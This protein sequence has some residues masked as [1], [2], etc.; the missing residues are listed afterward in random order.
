MHNCINAAYCIIVADSNPNMNPKESEHF[1]GC[2]CEA[3]PNLITDWLSIRI[4]C[5]FSYETFERD[6]FYVFINAKFCCCLAVLISNARHALDCFLFVR[7][8]H[9]IRAKFRIRVRIKKKFVASNPT[10]KKI[11]FRSTRL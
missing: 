10:K 2:Q 3:N 6:D 8:S 7:C 11:Q 1:A 9:R 5:R 4:Y